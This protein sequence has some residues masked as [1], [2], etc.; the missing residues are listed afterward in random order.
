[1][2]ISRHYSIS[3]LERK[4]S[5]GWK[6]ERPSVGLVPAKQANFF[7]KG[8]TQESLRVENKTSKPSVKCKQRE[9]NN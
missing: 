7:Q 5:T 9:E 3:G 4:K 1:M 8:H 6:P 2:G